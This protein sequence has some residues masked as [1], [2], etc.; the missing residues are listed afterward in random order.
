MALGKIRI[1]SMEV[2]RLAIG[3]NPFSGFSHQGDA[4]DLSM[5]QYYTTARIKAA[6]R[7]AED[8]G[9]NTFFGR[10]DN[11]VVRLLQE[12]WDEGGK[13][14]WMA[15]TAS[16]QADYIRNIK[17]A[18]AVGAKGIYVHGG[19][20]DVW[21]YNKDL[22]HFQKAL[23]E[24]RSHGLPGGFAGHRC[25]LHDWINQ[26]INTDFH[27]CCYYDPSPRTSRPDHVVMDQENWSPKDRDDMTRTIQTLKA[28][29]I[30][31]KVLAGGHNPVVPALEYAASKFRPQ[32]VMLIG[33]HLGDDEDI[34]AKTVDLFEKIVEKKAAP[35]GKGKADYPG[36][37][38]A[39]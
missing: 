30:H 4:R 25:E 19:V 12:Y 31:Y 9:I 29:A 7:K 2:S 5:R 11:H 38:P 36:I 13:I 24:V 6:L 26:N 10:I 3:G 33:F 28:P 39:M 1:G 16:E 18:A 35:A 15:Q 17:Q 8:A 20:T 22:S 21:Y 34:I 37:S 14:Q 27:M 23:D 32:D